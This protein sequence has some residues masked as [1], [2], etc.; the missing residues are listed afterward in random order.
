MW[1]PRVVWT[2][3]MLVTTLRHLWWSLTLNWRRPRK[4]ARWL[5]RNWLMWRWAWRWAHEGKS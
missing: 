1:W 3:L 5:H 2:G 4:I